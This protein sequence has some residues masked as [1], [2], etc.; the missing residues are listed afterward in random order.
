VTVVIDDR[1]RLR[2]LVVKPDGG[3]VLEQEV[4]VEEVSRLIA[5]STGKCRPADAKALTSF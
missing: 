2:E 1:F 3:V 5:D 4:V